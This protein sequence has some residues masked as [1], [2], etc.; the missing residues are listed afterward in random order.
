MLS[1]IK[2][3]IQNINKEY[4]VIENSGIGYKIYSSLSTLDKISLGSETKIF[5]YMHVREDNISLFGFL[6]QEELRV[7]ELL[8]SVS[9]IGPKAAISVLSGLSPSKFSLAVITNDIAVLKSIS[10]I[11]LKTAQRIILELRDKVK[12]EDGIEITEENAGLGG[13]KLEALNALQVLGYSS[14]DALSVLNQIDVEN[15]AIED[16]IKQALKSFS[17]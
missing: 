10:G 9:G 16:I 5:T 15:A 1:Y 13:K 2:G 11:G 17:R 14:K 12:S 4:L 6:T 3:T 7:F 8:I